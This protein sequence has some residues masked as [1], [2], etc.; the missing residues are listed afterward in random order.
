MV[1]PALLQVAWLSS[2]QV[3]DAVADDVIVKDGQRS[4]LDLAVLACAKIDLYSQRRPN[5][6]ARSSRVSFSG[7]QAISEAKVAVSLSV[8]TGDAPYGKH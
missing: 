4:Q 2:L 7:L 6:R 3:N 1:L 8:D 5:L